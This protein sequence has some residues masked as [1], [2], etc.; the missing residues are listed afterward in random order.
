M[1]IKIKNMNKLTEYVNN[2]KGA[3]SDETNSTQN[4]SSIEIIPDE[5]NSMINEVVKYLNYNYFD[6]KLDSLEKN[7]PLNSINEPLNI[8]KKADGSYV[9]ETLNEYEDNF[10]NCENSNE[11]DKYNLTYFN[12]KDKLIDCIK[13][14]TQIKD[15]KTLHLENLKIVINTAYIPKLANS[16]FLKQK[17]YKNAYTKNIFEP[18][19]YLLI[20]N[21]KG[22]PIRKKEHFNAINKL[23]LNLVD[24]NLEYLNYFYNYLAYK[25]QNLDK[26]ATSSIVFLGAQGVGKDTF[27]NLVLDKLF[28]SDNI[29]N[30]R[31]DAFKSGFMEFLTNKQFLIINESHT[32]T[33]SNAKTLQSILKQIT[34][35]SN[36][37]INAKYKAAGKTKLY[38]ATFVFSNNNEPLL[39]DESDR[40]FS[41]FKSGETL[42]KNKFLGF[43]NYENL[44][45]AIN[46]ELED[47]AIFLK[48][49]KVNESL[50][51]SCLDTPYKANIIKNQLTNLEKFYNII[52]N[53]DI[54]LIDEILQ[55][56]GISYENI[57]NQIFV[58][59]FKD[60]L[61]N[62]RLIQ[63]KVKE[64]YKSLFNEPLNWNQLR[65]IDIDLIFKN[66]YRSDGKTIIKLN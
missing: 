15:L 33:K 65:K 35:D 20:S 1:S 62:K 50:A 25:F 22:L 27:I 39:L 31:P 5:N 55:D 18:T 11:I 9:I 30:V 61:K 51:N 3:T 14:L 56:N 7:N 40:R 59:E 34:T 64:Y 66:N 44:K 32:D 53:R 45:S 29:S 17:N 24:N 6:W 26:R 46:K 8:Y 41:I 2:K 21:V 52:K 49:Y 58:K 12:S 13:E 42:I 63:P 23:C 38:N 10:L 57:D 48:Q 60:S 43:G 54:E 4:E 16:N 19:K 37:L 28:D 36:I 47:F